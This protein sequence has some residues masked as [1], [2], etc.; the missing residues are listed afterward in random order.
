MIYKLLNTNAENALNGTIAANMIALH[1]GANILRVHDVKEASECVKI[2]EN[3]S[4][5]IR[6]ND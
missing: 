3:S 4:L 2:F 1:N 6:K 5:Q